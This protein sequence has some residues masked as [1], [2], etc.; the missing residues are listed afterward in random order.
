M[1]WKDQQRNESLV[2]KKLTSDV[3]LPQES[4]KGTVAEA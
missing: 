1:W 4:L 3:K 2:Q